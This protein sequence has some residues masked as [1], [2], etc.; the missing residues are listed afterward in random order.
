MK[1]GEATYLENS[2]IPCLR[3]I[4]TGFWTTRSSVD[5]LSNTPAVEELFSLNIWSPCDARTDLSRKLPIPESRTRTAASHWSPNMGI[6]KIATFP[7][8]AASKM[9]LIPQWE[10]KTWIFPDVNKAY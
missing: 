5:T 7:A 1:C 4:H 6:Q 2:V 10:I 3:L 9:E 8:W